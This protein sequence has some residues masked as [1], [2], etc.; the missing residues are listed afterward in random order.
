MKKYLV[1]VAIAVVVGFAIVGLVTEVR[2]VFS[3]H[4]K[5]VTVHAPTAIPPGSKAPSEEFLVDYANYKTLQK[6]VRDLQ[7]DSKL[8]EKQRLLNGTAD[9]LREQVPPGMIFD[10]DTM[11]FKPR[12][13]TPAPPPPEPKKP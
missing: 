2:D 7:M 13:L 6:Q 12:Q 11:T 4:A 10:E 9:A 8:I 3:S 5:T 1:I